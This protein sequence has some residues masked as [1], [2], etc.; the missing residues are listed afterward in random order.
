MNKAVCKTFTNVYL[1]K[2]SKIYFGKAM[3]SLIES[4]YIC[5]QTLSVMS[6]IDGHLEDIFKI[7]SSSIAPNYDVLVANKKCNISHQILFLKFVF[8]VD[9]LLMLAVYCIFQ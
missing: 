2:S 8:S 4:T 5:E 7:S 6:L 1:K 3:F 9:F